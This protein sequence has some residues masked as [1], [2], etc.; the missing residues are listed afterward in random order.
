MTGKR[1]SIILDEQNN[2]DITTIKG[3]LGIMDMAQA[4]RWAVHE[5]A[6]QIRA[7]PAKALSS[8]TFKPVPKPS[9]KE[10]TYED[11]NDG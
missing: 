1:T 8:R 9:A 3:H 10:T 2:A 7:T 4:V 6:E 5:I 11:V